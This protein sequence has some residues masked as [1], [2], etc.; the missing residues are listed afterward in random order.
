MNLYVH[1]V[2]CRQGV[3]TGN[4]DPGA[5]VYRKSPPNWTCIMTNDGK[6]GAGVLLGL[7]L[8]FSFGFLLRKGESFSFDC[9]GRDIYHLYI[10]LA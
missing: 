5:I 8:D 3:D 4:I 6:M 9:F 10:A 1:F 7:V 2:H